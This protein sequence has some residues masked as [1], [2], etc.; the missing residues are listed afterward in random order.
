MTQSIFTQVQLSNG[1]KID[2]LEIKAGHYFQ[3][4]IMAGSMEF[5]KIF[6]HLLDA[7]LR[8]NGELLEDGYL[9]NLSMTDLALISEVIN[10]QSQPNVNL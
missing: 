7:V 8:K 2:V 9:D 3:A 4:M 10:V 5:P 1:D 6:K